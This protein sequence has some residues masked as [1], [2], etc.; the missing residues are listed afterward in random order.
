[1]E[2]EYVYPPDTSV[3]P[4][5]HIH[6][7][8]NVDPNGQYDSQEVTG[9]RSQWNGR[10]YGGPQINTSSTHG[11]NSPK[12]AN[13]TSQPNEPDIHVPDE[14]AFMS[15]G[16]QWTGQSVEGSNSGVDQS[17]QNSKTAGSCNHPTKDTQYR[18]YIDN[19]WVS[20][21][22]GSCA[23]QEGSLPD[24]GAGE[25]IKWNTPYTAKCVGQL[26]QGYV[27]PS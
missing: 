15:S 22:H 10:E 14:A 1:M 25:V 20:T 19:Q 4:R 26:P 18:M 6:S 16:S 8:H 12:N 2:W 24:M 11:T 17:P 9:G 21:M 7:E 23:F 27:G 5:T 13:S 3:C